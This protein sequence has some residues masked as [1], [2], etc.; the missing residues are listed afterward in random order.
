MKYLH[1]MMRGCYDKNRRWRKKNSFKDFLL[2]NV[3]T[4]L[5]CAA[6]CAL[7]WTGLCCAVQSCMYIRTCVYMYADV[8]MYLSQLFHCVVDGNF[9]SMR[10]CIDSSC[11][12]SH[13][14]FGL[15]FLD[16]IVPRTLAV[17]HGRNDLVMF[18]K[19]AYLTC[20][21]LLRPRLTPCWKLQKYSPS[22]A[23]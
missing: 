9:L 10:I 16:R 12:L 15:P 4:G 8:C 13:S 1:T 19:S 14:Q 2:M 17:R 6:Y 22:S 20:S 18:R 5:Y 23:M 3:C 21:N 11:L 7:R